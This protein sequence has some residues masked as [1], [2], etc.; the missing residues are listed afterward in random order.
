MV[1]VIAISRIALSLRS[2]TSCRLLKT[3]EDSDLLDKPFS[4]R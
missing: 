1:M 4:V 3:T 2:H